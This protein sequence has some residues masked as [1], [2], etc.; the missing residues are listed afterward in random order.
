MNSLSCVTDG[1]DLRRVYGLFPT[2]VT[3]LCAM[4]DDRP[5]G[6][7]ARAF[8]AISLQ[9]A[10]VGVCIQQGSRTWRQLRTRERLGVSFLGESHA[11]TARRLAQKTGDRFA[12]ASY[13]VS[14]QGAVFLADAAAW[15]EVSV[16][17]QI[18]A[19]DHDIVVLRLHRVAVADGVSPLVFHASDFCTLAP[20]G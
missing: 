10:L 6:M 7:T 15:L 2:G 3:A 20:L 17:N 11:M 1:A 8:V 4:V 12:G 13:Q 16:E 9:P 5:A 18:P 14:P 19:G